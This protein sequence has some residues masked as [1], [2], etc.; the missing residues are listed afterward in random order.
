MSTVLNPVSGLIIV[1][2]HVMYSPVTEDKDLVDM[3]GSHHIARN[4]FPKLIR[5]PE[6][7]T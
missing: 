5:K 2:V 1:P 4:F 6:C 3:T 7:T